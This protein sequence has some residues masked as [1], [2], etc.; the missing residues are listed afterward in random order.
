ML[1][2]KQSTNQH[3]R[4]HNVPNT[5]QHAHSAS[6][7]PHYS[8]PHYNVTMNGH[9]HHVGG[10]QLVNGNQLNFK[11]LYTQTQN[12][13]QSMGCIP[14]Q[15]QTYSHN[16]YNSVYTNQNNHFLP[17][18]STGISHQNFSLNQNSIPPYQN[19]SFS[20]NSNFMS[21]QNQQNLNPH[22]QSL[23]G[24]HNQGYGSHNQAHQKQEEFKWNDYTGWAGM[25]K[26]HQSHQPQQN[27]QEPQ[28]VQVQ[29]G[30]QKS[31]L[32]DWK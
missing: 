27:Q 12:P 30:Q 14:A 2:K 6:S 21:N 17:Q 25:G 23:G 1:A 32:D 18:N 8:S 9:T 20:L 7:I 13:Y 26:H 28:Q 31:W 4:Y 29:Q 15:N 24:Y 11:Q 16:Q 19:N 5:M 10:N 3:M 22:G